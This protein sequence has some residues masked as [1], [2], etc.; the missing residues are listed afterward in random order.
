MAHSCCAGCF[1]AA[2]R[3]N[4]EMARLSLR[5]SERAARLSVR[6]RLLLRVLALGLPF[7]AY[8]A[9]DAAGEARADR[10]FAKERSLAVAREIT[11]ASCDGV[12]S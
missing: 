12:E 9:I 3:P 10:E 11:P 7:L 8:I 4:N 1:R 2:E 6:G 5:L